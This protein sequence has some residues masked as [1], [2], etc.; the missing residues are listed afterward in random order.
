MSYDVKCLELAQHFLQD[1]QGLSKADHDKYAAEI[2]Q[3][4]QWVVEDDLGSIQHD[5]TQSETD[6]PHLLPVMRA[7]E[8]LDPDGIGLTARA[9]V[10][11]LFDTRLVEKPHNG[12]LQEARDAIETIARAMHGATP[13]PI[14]LGKFLARNRG[15]LVSGKAIRR[16]LGHESDVTIRWAVET[17]SG[18]SPEVTAQR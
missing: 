2:A 13:D 17:T 11:R 7:I 9:I 10:Q 12:Q 4:V 5:R 1:V 6:L 8:I 16:R 14:R 18:T 3:H 15:R